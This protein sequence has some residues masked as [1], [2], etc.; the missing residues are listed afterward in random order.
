MTRMKVLDFPL[1]KDSDEF[2]K[3][4]LGE[5]TNLMRK[6]AIKHGR[7]KAFELLNRFGVDAIIYLPYSVWP[8]FIQ[9]LQKGLEGDA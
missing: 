9:A 1:A 4:P 5:I 6:F 3:R 8:E 2:R 7:K